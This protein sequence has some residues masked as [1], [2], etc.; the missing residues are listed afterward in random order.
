MVNFY[1][2][3]PLERPLKRPKEEVVTTPLAQPAVVESDEE[4]GSIPCS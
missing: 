1:P 2:R 3:N 4:E